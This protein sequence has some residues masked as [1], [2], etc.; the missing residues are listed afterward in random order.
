VNE[1][2]IKLT[3]DDIRMFTSGLTLDEVQS[4][5]VPIWDETFSQK[6]FPLNF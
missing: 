3:L 5:A 6:V 2:S 4:L 1:Q